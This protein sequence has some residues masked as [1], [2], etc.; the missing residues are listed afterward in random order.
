MYHAMAQI[1]FI[2]V[3]PKQG[4]P[5]YIMKKF[6]FVQMLEAIQKHKITVLIMVPP[7]VV[8]RFIVSTLF[9]HSY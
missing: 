1:L 5:V 9:S 7:M 3:A 2:V 8:V 6:D 4:I